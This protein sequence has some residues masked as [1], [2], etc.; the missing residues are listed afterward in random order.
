MRILQVIDRDFSLGRDD[1]DINDVTSM[2][3]VNLSEES[4]RILATNSDLVGSQVRSCQDSF[5]VNR[6]ALVQKLKEAG[7]S[8]VQCVSFCQ[9][10]C[11]VRNQVKKIV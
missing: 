8:Y 4:D 3:G 10:Q 2:A 6:S 5:I 11:H 7:K 1:D 9:Y